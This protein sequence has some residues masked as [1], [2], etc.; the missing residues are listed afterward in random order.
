MQ[1]SDESQVQPYSHA[2]LSVGDIDV[3]SM[4]VAKGYELASVDK[5]SS[6]KVGFM[7]PK[8]VEMEQLIRDY[9][10]DKVEVHAMAFANARKNLKSRIFGLDTI[11][12]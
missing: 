6:K 10:L 5:M 12:F 2:M 7:F 3:A 8:T 9:W 4:L 11:N 1:T